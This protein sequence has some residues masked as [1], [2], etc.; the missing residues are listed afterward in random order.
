MELYEEEFTLR[1]FMFF[2]Q[3]KMIM[4]NVQKHSCINKGSLEMLNIL[5]YPNKAFMRIFRLCNTEWLVYKLN[6]KQRS[7]R[8]SCP[9]NVVP[10]FEQ[11]ENIH[12]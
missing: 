3:K 4:G 11:K 5:D 2:K 1:N 6:W 10:K 9:K 12:I 7:E 8:R